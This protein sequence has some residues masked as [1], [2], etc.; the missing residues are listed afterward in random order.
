MQVLHKLA[1]DDLE[2]MLKATNST[3]EYI[4]WW[5]AHRDADAREATEDGEEGETDDQREMRVMEVVMDI[6][7]KRKTPDAST[8]AVDD[9]IG[10]V[11]KEG[12]GPAPR[13][14][15]HASAGLSSA[16]LSSAGL[17]SAGLSA[18]HSGTYVAVL[19]W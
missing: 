7:S 12:C 9:L 11:R 4:A 17:S 6:T 8:A 1:V 16:G 5:Q 10:S 2:L 3:S 18:L 15:A 19:S 14:G 13:L